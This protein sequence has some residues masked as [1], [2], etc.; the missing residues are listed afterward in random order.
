MENRKYILT[1]VTLFIVLGAYSQEENGY[2][3]EGNNLYKSKKYTEAEIAYRKGL[4][5]NSKSTEAAYNLGNAL[6]KQE[7]YAEALEQYQRVAPSEKISK[8]NLSAVLHNTG[9]A[10]LMEKKVTESIEAYKKSLKVNPTDDDTRYNLAYAQ[11]L[12]KQQQNQDNKDNQDNKQEK[13][14]KN[15]Q[16]PD[17]KDKQQENK[18]DQQE[19]KPQPS[20]L[21]KENAEQVLQALMQDEQ[22]TMEK[23][24]KQPVGSRKGTDKDW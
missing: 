11:Q 22:D 4:Q 8:K 7:K 16:K 19:E 6:F 23:A 9:N 2:I 17:E 3:R 14:K 21:S 12:L 1:I 10:L 20:D 13:D 5:I 18:K 24:K 15:Q